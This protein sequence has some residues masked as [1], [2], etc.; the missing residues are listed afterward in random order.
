M[1]L[2][3]IEQSNPQYARP[4]TTT[5]TLYSSYLGRRQDVSI[6]A[7]NSQSTDL[8]IVVLLHGVYGNNW[9][10]MDLGGVHQVYEELRQQGLSEFILVM[11]S[12]GGIWDGSAYLPLGNFGDFDS[13]IVKDVLDAVKQSI[14]MASENSRVYLSG[15]SMGGFG[16][17][18]LG[19]KYAQDI[20]GISAHSAITKVSDLA[21]FTDTALENYKTHDANEADI[22]YWATKNHQIMPP[23]RFDCG[24]DD[25]LFHSNQAFAKALENSDISY[26]F[27]INDGAHEWE[28]WT[29]HVAQTLRFFDAIELKK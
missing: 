3:R 27:D 7:Q 4:N 24:R 29:K 9:V 26:V 17:L 21:L 12:D 16:A 14:P 15:L 8:P 18:R 23:L 28:Y 19:C 11:P 10:W 22:I 20:S 1:T 5:L 25:E 2:L 13:W 6:Y